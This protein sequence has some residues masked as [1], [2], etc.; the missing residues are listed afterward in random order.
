[1]NDDTAAPRGARTQGFGFTSLSV[2]LG[3]RVRGL[4]GLGGWSASGSF[5]TSGGLAALVAFAAFEALGAL[6][7]LAAFSAFGAFAALVFGA[8][9]PVGR[10]SCRRSRANYRAPA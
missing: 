7:A 9:A 10:T 1:M 8:L 4:A 5:A 3:R 2:R 6:G